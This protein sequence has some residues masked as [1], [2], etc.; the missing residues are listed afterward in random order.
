MRL[1]PLDY[2]LETP[3]VLAVD[4]SWK[5]VRFY[6]YQEEPSG[7]KKQK[8]IARFRSITLNEREARFS[9]PKR[10]L[11]GSMR[12]LEAN[13]LWP[14][15]CQKLI[16]ETDAKFLKGMLTNPSIAPNA[17]INRWIENVLMYHFTLRHCPGKTFGPDGLSRRD[18]QLGDKDYPKPEDW[19]DEPAG[20]EGIEYPD[21]PYEEPLEPEEFHDKIDYRGGYRFKVGH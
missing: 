16:V 5:A 13:K 7:D 3:V 20:L 12:A 2:E 1:K 17:T 9:Q 6:I 15:G 4:T 14:L 21:E 19:E 11:F 8:W 18:P 10:E